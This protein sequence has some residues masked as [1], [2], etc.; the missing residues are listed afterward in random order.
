MA[1]VTFGV[2]VAEFELKTNKKG[3]IND[4]TQPSCKSLLIPDVQGESV[5]HS[6]TPYE[7]QKSHLRW[8]LKEAERGDNV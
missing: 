5:Q 2:K 3:E 6:E 8:T 7:W 1:P 4:I